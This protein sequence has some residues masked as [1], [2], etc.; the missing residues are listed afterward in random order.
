MISTVRIPNFKA[1]NQIPDDQLHHGIKVGS[2]QQNRRVDL[3][4]SRVDYQCVVA[5]VLYF[6]IS[7]QNIQISEI[8][9]PRKPQHLEVFHVRCFFNSRMCFKLGN[10][11]VTDAAA[12]MFPSNR[13]LLELD[14]FI[15]SFT[16][17]LLICRAF[18]Q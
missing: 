5:R 3:I 15:M 11:N 17:L 2:E 14:M 9:V 13:C 7:K 4:V 10:G 1:E 16:Q 6:Q 18:I 8:H 12:W